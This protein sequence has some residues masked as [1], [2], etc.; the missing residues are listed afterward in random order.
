MHECVTWTLKVQ[1]STVIISWSLSRGLQLCLCSGFWDWGGWSSAL[2]LCSFPPSSRTSPGSHEE[3][4][5]RRR[6]RRAQVFVCRAEDTKTQRKTINREIQRRGRQR[7]CST[8]TEDGQ[9]T[10]FVCLFV[11]NGPKLKCHVD[12]KVKSTKKIQKKTPELNIMGDH[13]SGKVTEKFRWDA[14]Q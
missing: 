5:R 6:R 2:Q 12:I 8:R 10:A 3:R 14:K 4:R 13:R 11:L 9:R 1:E 7:Q